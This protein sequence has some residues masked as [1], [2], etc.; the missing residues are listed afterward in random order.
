VTIVDLRLQAARVFARLLAGDVRLYNEEAVLTGRTRGDLSSRL[1][2]PLRKAR[3]RYH[4]RFSGIDP[5]Q[6]LLR[7]ELI[8]AVAGGRE[9]L[10]PDSPDPESAEHAQDPASETATVPST[11]S[12]I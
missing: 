1:A 8:N 3:A 5:T 10:L 4:A 11:G 2:D 12:G 6:S 9:D 7:T